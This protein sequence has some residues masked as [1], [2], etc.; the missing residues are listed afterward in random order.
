MRA[1]KAQTNLEAMPNGQPDA[2]HTVCRYSKVAK[3]IGDPNAGGSLSLQ[4]LIASIGL[5]GMLL[6]ATNERVGSL[7]PSAS[8]NTTTAPEISAEKVIVVTARRAAALSLLPSKRIVLHYNTDLPSVYKYAVLRQAERL[9]KEGYHAIAIAGSSED[10]VRLYAAGKTSEKLFFDR[11]GILDMSPLNF[12]Y[13]V[14]EMLVGPPHTS[15]VDV[16]GL[17]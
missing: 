14:H 2:K 5:S 8:A 16:M 7:E 17:E 11:G 9:R 3:M 10:G 1:R 15:P 4:R 13:K 12:G 6:V